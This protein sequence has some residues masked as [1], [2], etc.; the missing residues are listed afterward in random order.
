MV[1]KSERESWLYDFTATCQRGKVLPPAKLALD[2]NDGAY[3]LCLLPFVAKGFS[4]VLNP[5]EKYK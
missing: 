4:L 3:A 5:I 1:I 2:D